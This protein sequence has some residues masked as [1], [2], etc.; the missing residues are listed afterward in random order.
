[1]YAL[2]SR[3]MSTILLAITLAYAVSR[4]IETTVTYHNVSIMQAVN[5]HVK[6]SGASIPIY[7]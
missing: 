3:D 6:Y 7:R 1:M 5:E 4:R 2:L